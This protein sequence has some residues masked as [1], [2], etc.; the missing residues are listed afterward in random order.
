MKNR[1]ILT[2]LPIGVAT[3]LAM[4]VGTLV[5]LFIGKNP[6]DA[7]RAM[8]TYLDSADSVVAVINRANWYYV[9]GLAAAIGFRMGL[10]NIGV[11]GQYRMAALLTAALGAEVSLPAVLHVPFMF[12]VAMAVGGAYAAIPGVLK[13]KRGVNE[14][15]ATI[16]LNYVATGII[17]YL[18]INYFWHRDETGRDLIPKTDLLPRS[19]W[20]P[21]LN[22]LIA[23]FGLDFAPGVR[24]AASSSSRHWPGWCSIS[25][26]GALASASTYGCRASILWLPAPRA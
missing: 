2:F 10:F 16:M 17:A 11:D 14:V 1:L 26:S 21:D 8:G 7:A 23:K 25:S 15:I 24:V 20:L 19:A 18:L 22:A 9:S 6:L 13:V 4:V 12:I 5:L 3:L